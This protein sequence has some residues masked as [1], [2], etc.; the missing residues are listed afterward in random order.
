[1]SSKTFFSAKEIELLRERA[2]PEFIHPGEYS[3]GWSKSKYEPMKVLEAFPSLSIK[4]GFVLRAYQFVEGGNGN[5]VVWAMPEDCSFPEPNECD[6]LK[7]TFL[8]CPRPEGAIDVMDVISGDGSE[9]SYISA[10]IFCREISELGAYWHGSSWS[11]HTIIDEDTKT[12][13]F[14]FEKIKDWEW[15][16]EKPVNFGPSVKKSEDKTF[17]VF[18]THSG[19]M[20]GGLYKHIDIY[21]NNSYRPKLNSE[22]IAKGGNQYLY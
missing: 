1:M 10:S 15:L 18:Y 8:E 13:E 9:L 11:S 3:G 21:D 6:K 16:E 17:V 19:L 2:K 14:D 20:P 4:S 22:R 5:G 7:D 12:E